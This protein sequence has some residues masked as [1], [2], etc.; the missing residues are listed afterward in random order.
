MCVFRAS[1]EVKGSCV[2]SVQTI[3]WYRSHVGMWSAGVISE[4]GT[5]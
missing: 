4:E 5:K 1:D 2:G 3:L